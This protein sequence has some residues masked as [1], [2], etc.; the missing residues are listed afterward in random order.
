MITNDNGLFIQD[1]ACLGYLFNFGQRGVF[2]PDGKVE[3]T[4]EAADAHN[5]LLG[6]AELL[7]LDQNCQVGQG[8]TFY[9]IRGL[10]QTWAGLLVSDKV[11]KAGSSITFS[12]N[13]KVF[14]GRLQKDAD[15]FNF[16]RV[17]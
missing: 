12:R 8:G 6:E 15:C 16:R 10:V 4:A 11:K 3:I 13:G 9:Y 1:G 5:R 17:S 2:S 14:R 7:G